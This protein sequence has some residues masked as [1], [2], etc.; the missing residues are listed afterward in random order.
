MYAAVIHPLALS[1][2]WML[3]QSPDVFN[4]GYC[5]PGNTFL[6]DKNSWPGPWRTLSQPVG[7]AAMIMVCGGIMAAGEDDARG[8]ARWESVGE[9]SAGVGVRSTCEEEGGRIADFLG[10]RRL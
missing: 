1:G 4:K 3:Y 5:S 10:K 8:S 6:N 9:G 7:V 2:S